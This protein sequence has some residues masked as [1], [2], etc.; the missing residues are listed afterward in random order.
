M[1][2][3]PKGDKF[4]GL[5]NYLKQ[6]G[7]DTLTLTFEQIEGYIGEKLQPSA[8]NYGAYW[9]NT[10]THSIAHSWF[11]AAYRTTKK[12]LKNRRITFVKD[13]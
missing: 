10:K 12:D 7:L 9:S 1:E 8:Y 5:E 2:N 3:M 6:C 13:N 4:I 11:N